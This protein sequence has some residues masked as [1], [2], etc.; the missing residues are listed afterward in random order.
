MK[1]LALATLLLAAPALI[2]AQQATE[3]K[4]MNAIAK[5]EAFNVEGARPDLLAIISPG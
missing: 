4:L 2:R 1:R 5:Y 3:T